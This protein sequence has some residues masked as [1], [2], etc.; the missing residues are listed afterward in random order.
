M[1][2]IDV[3]YKDLCNLIGKK[4]SAEE[5]EN[6]VLYAKGE[7]DSIDNDAIKIDI[8]DTNRP[9]LWSA[10]GICRE[11]RGRVTK[12]VG[13]PDYSVGKSSVVVNVDKKVSKVR[14]L[15][16]CAV[17]KNLK[18]NENILSQMIQLQEKVSGTFG[19]NRKEV[20]IG[21]YDLN[22]ITPP[23]KYTTVKPDGIKF[24]PLEFKDKLT[25]REILNKHP[26]GKE[27][28][29]LLKDCEE[30]PIFI[31]S[32]NNVLSLP[33]IINSDYT[34]KVTE[35]TTDIFIECS[36]FRLKFLLPALNT[37]VA[38]LADRGGK[39]ETVKIVY[40]D[41]VLNTPD[42]TPKKTFV[43][44]DYVNKISGLNLNG[45]KICQLLEQAR[46][47]TILKGKRIELLY[48]AYRQDIM[49]QRDVV[50]D[51]IISFGY[52]KIEPLM[53]KLPVIG[54]ESELEIFSNK[55]S[56]VLIGLGLQE[57]MSYTLTS[58]KNLFEKMNLKNKRIVEIEN[59]V[60][61]NRSVFRSWILP[62]LL[63]FLSK[64]KHVDYPQNIFEIG[65]AVNID[66]KRETGTVNERKLAVV[67]TDNTIG[68]EEISSYL[69]ALMKNLGIDYK[70]RATE[71]GSFI[72]GRVA[73]ILINNNSIGIIGEINPLVL[74]KWNLE[75]PVAGFEMSVDMLRVY[76]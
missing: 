48:P 45:K 61:M 26:K 27:F 12:D 49:H 74:E 10:E 30:Y 32:A 7:I 56:E 1:P 62:S 68:Y 22:K 66:E 63:E 53:P 46:Y 16:V 50:E 38:A 6:A 33:P 67:L 57:I 19:R 2:T 34:G 36:G 25:P 73:K 47:K 55:I 3:S 5:L 9:D 71:H 70:L 52:N 14:P 64:N 35:K 72:P 23:I 43:D 21:V 11:M 8:K 40:P 75:K 76:K 18:M 58:K 59:P 37:I 44:V 41:T 65:D 39:L 4:L 42:F 31:D 51:V 20:A 69:D 13:L 24:V 54:S 17:V 28:G 60:S 15:T 29:H